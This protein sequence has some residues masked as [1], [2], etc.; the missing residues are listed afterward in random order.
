MK[1]P[2]NNIRTQ[3]GENIGDQI[4]GEDAY[5]YS[6]ILTASDTW[7]ILDSLETHF[8]NCEQIELE[9]LVT[10]WKRQLEA[11]FPDMEMA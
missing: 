10:G 4:Q 2:D 7:C 3:H 9:A 11:R 1:T 5:G 6:G 8:M